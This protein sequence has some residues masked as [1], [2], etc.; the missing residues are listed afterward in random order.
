MTKA[1]NLK[2][3][4]LKIHMTKSAKNSHRRRNMDFRFFSAFQCFSVS[5]F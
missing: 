3:E 4:M 2:T 1:E 5:A